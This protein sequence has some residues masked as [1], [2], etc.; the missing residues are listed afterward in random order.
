MYLLLHGTIPKQLPWT[1]H[2]SL[3]SFFDISNIHFMIKPLAVGLRVK[4]V[5]ACVHHHTIEILNCFIPEEAESPYPNYGGNYLSKDS[6]TPKEFSNEK[7]CVFMDVYLLINR[8][9]IAPTCHPGISNFPPWQGY[10]ISHEL[11]I[12]HYILSQTKH[13]TCKGACTNSTMQHRQ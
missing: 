7:C 8:Q 4:V 2:F 13:V 6:L 9:Q 10:G 3:Q 11:H 12:L 1:I 5:V